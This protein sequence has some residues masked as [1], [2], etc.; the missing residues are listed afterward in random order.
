MWNWTGWT[1]WSASYG[2]S[3]FHLMYVNCAFTSQSSQYRGPTHIYASCLCEQGL[4]LLDNFFWRAYGDIIP[5][6]HAVL[7]SRSRMHRLAV[8]SVRPEAYRCTIQRATLCM[9]CLNCVWVKWPAQGYMP[10]TIS[11]SQ[12]HV[13]TYKVYIDPTCNIPFQCRLH[14]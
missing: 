13:Y 5:S 6:P 7:A 3:G 11:H 1:Y 10:V 2:S 4:W 8:W 12:G 9:S 14:I